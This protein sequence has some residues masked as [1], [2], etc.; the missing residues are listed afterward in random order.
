M[1][2][3]DESSFVIC[4]NHKTPY[5]VQKETKHRFYYVTIMIHFPVKI[6]PYQLHGKY[7]KNTRRITMGNGLKIKNSRN[8]MCR[9]AYSGAVI[10]KR[11]LIRQG[12][13]C[14]I[15]LRYLDDI[16]IL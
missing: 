2:K 15:R 7:I 6:I 10:Q 4:H 3:T 5:K 1:I 14:R 11:R 12:N 8:F 16:F 9:G 13:R